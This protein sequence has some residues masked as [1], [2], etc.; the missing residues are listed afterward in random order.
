MRVAEQQD[1]RMETWNSM[2]AG[3]SQ[4]GHNGGPDQPGQEVRTTEEKQ[5][6]KRS[7]EQVVQLCFFVFFSFFSW[8]TVCV[9]RARPPRIYPALISQ[10]RLQLIINQ[11]HSISTANLAAA[12][13][14]QT[15]SHQKT[16]LVQSRV[17]LQNL[18]AVSGLQERNDSPKIRDA[19]G[20]Q[21]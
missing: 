17:L 13:P 3:R 18:T 2:N 10:L 4:K 16:R 1:R 21:L 12:Q 6:S 14:A 11:E 8:V 20:I 19:R 15:P 9:C 5:R 7:K